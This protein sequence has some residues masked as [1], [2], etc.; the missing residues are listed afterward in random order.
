MRIGLT[1]QDSPAILILL[2][3]RIIECLM[4][5]CWASFA[6]RLDQGGYGGGFEK[7]SVSSNSAQELKI[8]NAVI[9]AS[10][11]KNRVRDPALE[12]ALRHGSSVR[13]QTV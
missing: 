1:A 9:V 10:R 4:L 8:R 2:F 6:L 12:R 13:S 7:F 3:W 11:V 5:G